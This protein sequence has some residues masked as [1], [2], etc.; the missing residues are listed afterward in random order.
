MWLDDVRWYYQNAYFD[1]NQNKR[2]TFWLE[3]SREPY[4]S[5]HLMMKSDGGQEKILQVLTFGAEL[6][7]ITKQ[8][9]A[10]G[11]NKWKIQNLEIT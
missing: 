9:L 6:K 10:I 4:G 7:S 5:M 2:Y 8:V 1:A 11:W 3:R